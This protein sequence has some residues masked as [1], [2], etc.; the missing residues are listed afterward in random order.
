MEIGTIQSLASA[1][2]PLR[3]PR[4]G[5]PLL[6]A[7]GV[8]L[9]VTLASPEHE[10]VRAARAAGNRRMRERGD[11]TLLDEAARLEAIEDVSIEVVAAAVLAWP[12]ITVDGERITRD[13]AAD[14][15]ARPAMRWLYTQLLAELNTARNFIAASALH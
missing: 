14:L 10:A 6:D 9:C 5:E 11:L 3:H 2:V 12:D 13:N 15:L 4:T 7:S 8:A 1:L